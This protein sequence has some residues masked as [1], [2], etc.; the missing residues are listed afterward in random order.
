MA[1]ATAKYR[2]FM[3]DNHQGASGKSYED[4]VSFQVDEDSPIYTV[5]GLADSAINANTEKVYHM[6]MCENDRLY[7]LISIEITE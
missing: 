7:Q 3:S 1:V 4:S 6:T 5:F 2:A